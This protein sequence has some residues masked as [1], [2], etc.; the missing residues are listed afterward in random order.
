MLLQLE[1][2][3][4]HQMKV[5]SAVSGLHGYYSRMMDCLVDHISYQ[6]GFGWNI[7]TSGEFGQMTV[8]VSGDG[9]ADPVFDSI[10]IGGG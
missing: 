8:I 6:V 9:S 2:Y 10:S 7:R 1:A 3:Y 4:Q 5:A